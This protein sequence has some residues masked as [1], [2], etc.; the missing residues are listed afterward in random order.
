MRQDNVAGEEIISTARARQPGGGA[1][2][3]AISNEMVRVYK[4]YLGRGPTK[5]NTHWAGPDVLVCVLEDTL[6]QAEESLVKIAAHERLREIRTVFQDA[7][8]RQFCEPV[9]RLTGRKVRSF[10]S[11]IDTEVKGL[12]VEMFVLHPAGSDSPSRIDVAGD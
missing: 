8:I 5:V 4:A 7:M 11:G 10:I 12:S 1:V 2:L 3:A 6:V 9:E